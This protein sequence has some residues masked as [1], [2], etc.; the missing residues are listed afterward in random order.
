MFHVALSTDS[1][2]IFLLMHIKFYY[3]YKISSKSR[4]YDIE[5]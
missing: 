5:M 3:T 2:K 4:N 1:Y